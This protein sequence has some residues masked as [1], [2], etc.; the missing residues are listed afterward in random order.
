MIILALV[1]RIQTGA[2]FRYKRRKKSDESQNPTS[3]EI[4]LS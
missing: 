1:S 3:Y 2:I 4:M